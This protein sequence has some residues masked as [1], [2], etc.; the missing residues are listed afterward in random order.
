M[1]SIKLRIGLAIALYSI[2][3]LYQLFLNDLDLLPLN[4]FFAGITGGFTVLLLSFF[5]SAGLVRDI[6][7]I[8]TVWIVVH[9]IG[10]VMYMCY[11]P[12]NV[13]NVSQYALN[14]IQLLWLIF[15]RHDLQRHRLYNDRD[16]GLPNA[17]TRLYRSYIKG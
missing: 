5:G 9:T 3:G 17:N 16:S 8:Q 12:P 7:I 11:L 14:I 6:K 15:A 13:Y 10:F 2:D 1:N 4:Y